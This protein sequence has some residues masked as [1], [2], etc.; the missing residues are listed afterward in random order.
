MHNESIPVPTDA[1]LE[2]LQVLWNAPNESVRHVNETINK[3]RAEAQQVG[4]TTT[5]K[6]M[7]VMLDKGLLLREIEGRNHLYTAA[8]SRDITQTKVV[9]E[10][11]D[12][13][14]NGNAMSLALHALGSG[15]TTTAELEEIKAMI[16]NIEAQQI[17]D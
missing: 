3:R 5:L 10:V 8:Q 15:K 17:K 7:Q 9:Q 14:F 11:A 6:Q 12:L 13:A 1:E 16:R 2:I 4:Y